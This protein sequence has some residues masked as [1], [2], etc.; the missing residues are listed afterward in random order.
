MNELILSFRN[1]ND[2]IAGERKLL[3]AG[4]YVLMTDAPKSMENG[5]KI[6]LRIKSADIG[7]VRLILGNT[8]KN[9]ASA[10]LD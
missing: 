3:D 4:V 8:I 6:C 10:P 7:K 9:E 2:A 1:T 5:C